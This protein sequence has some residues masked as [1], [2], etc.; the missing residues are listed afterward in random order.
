M[1]IRDLQRQMP[2]L[3]L[4]WTMEQMDRMQLRARQGASADVLA[5]EFDT[6]IVEINALAKR[7]GFYVKP[8]RMVPRLANVSLPVMGA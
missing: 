5:F 7:N 1:S 8:A 2:H 3:N 4:M 6:T